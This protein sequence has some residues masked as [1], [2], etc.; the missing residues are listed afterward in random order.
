MKLAWYVSL[1]AQAILVLTLWRSGRRD[2]WT[3]FLLADLARFLLLCAIPI[4]SHAYYWAW[5]LTE[6]P[7]M[8]PQFLAVEQ[9]TRGG[10]RE[11]VHVGIV[12]AGSL[13]SWSILLTVNE[14]PTARRAS[15]MLKQGA[16]YGCFAVLAA[17]LAYSGKTDILMLAFY[18]LGVMRVIAAQ[19][20]ISTTELI[21]TMYLGSVAVM[22][23]WW[24][25]FHKKDAEYD[26]LY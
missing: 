10:V 20:T 22:F 9:A 4:R 19:A 23:L 12:V 13:L 3:V 15:L 11:V 2:W 26:S 1:L 25:I 7:M 16:V 14:W 8:V 6:V 18:A 21:D 5:L 17:P 24:A